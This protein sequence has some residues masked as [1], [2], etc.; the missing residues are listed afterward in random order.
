MKTTWEVR[1]R[2]FNGTQ[3]G[4]FSKKEEAV[5]FLKNHLGLS[6]RPYLIRENPGF[7]IFRHKDQNGWND[8]Y[9]IIRSVK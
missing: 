8:T 9:I 7:Y 5:Q 4:V 1:K 2:D 6:Y 3:M